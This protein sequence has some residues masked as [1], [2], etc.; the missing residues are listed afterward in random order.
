MHC[1]WESIDTDD[2]DDNDG[3][4]LNLSYYLIPE[5]CTEYNS[6][7]ANF[8]T[9]LAYLLYLVAGCALSLAWAFAICPI[10]HREEKHGMSPPIVFCSRSS[11]SSLL[12]GSKKDKVDFRERE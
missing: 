8:T 1:T 6:L 3:H 5:Y 12:T 11:I 9:T 2:N 7:S 4:T 10:Y